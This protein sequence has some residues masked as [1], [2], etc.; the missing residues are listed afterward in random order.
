MAFVVPLVSDLTGLDNYNLSGQSTFNKNTSDLIN[1]FLS[2]LPAPVCLIAHN[3]NAYDFP[4]LKA[5]LEKLG[6]KLDA[7]ILCADSY[8][9]IKEIFSKKEETKNENLKEIADDYNAQSDA[10]VAREFLKSG[11]FNTDLLEG[12]TVTLDENESTPRHQKKCI[13]LIKPRNISEIFHVEH[14]K[15]RK[16]LHFPN[17]EP[18]SSFSLVNLH[19]HILGVPPIQ[20]HGA[21]ADCLALLRITSTLGSDWINWVKGNCYPFSSRQK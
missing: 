18:P 13:S 17:L 21:E 15:I 2:C 14:P 8:R 20:A 5:E 4:L 3:G 1:N 12:Q 10:Y 6:T 16:R 19:M 11:M 7:E 9:G